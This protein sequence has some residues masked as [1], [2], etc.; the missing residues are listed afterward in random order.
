VNHFTVSNHLTYP[1]LNKTCTTVW[2]C[3]KQYSQNLPVS[4]MSSSTFRFLTI[5]F[6]ESSKRSKIKC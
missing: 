2:F 4:F 6:F 3:G 1:V 5:Y